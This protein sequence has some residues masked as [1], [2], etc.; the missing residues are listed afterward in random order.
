[1]AEKSPPPHTNLNKTLY[2]GPTFFE[3]CSDGKSVLKTSVAFINNL[4]A[5]TVIVVPKRTNFQKREAVTSDAGTFPL[6]DFSV[7][8]EIYKHSGYTVLF[9]LFRK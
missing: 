1:M 9:E 2:A 3:V 6:P 7:H 8:L 4:E 5:E